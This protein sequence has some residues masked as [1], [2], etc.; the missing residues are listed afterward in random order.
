M[1]KSVKKTLD[2]TAVVLACILFVVGIMLLS[3]SL[4]KNKDGVPRVFGVTLLDIRTDSMKGTINAGDI[5][6]ISKVKDASDLK[7]GDVITF[8]DSIDGQRVL[9]THRIV[10]IRYNEQNPENTL[11]FTKGDNVGENDPLAKSFAQVVGKYKF[12]MAGLGY[13]VRF[14]QSGWGF[15]FIIILPLAAFLGYRVYILVKVI[16]DM[17]KEKAAADAA[18]QEDAEKLKAELEALRQKVAALEENKDGKTSP[19]TLDK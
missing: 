2:I 8:W 14:L 4:T 16:L 7:V 3:M 6:V 19:P 12:R 9:N 5:A 1:K 18:G 17:K 15:F 13:V 10:E 11:F